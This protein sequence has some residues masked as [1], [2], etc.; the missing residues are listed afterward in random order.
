MK[1]S[2]HIWKV[3]YGLSTRVEKEEEPDEEK[4]GE[5]ED[6]ESEKEEVVEKEGEKDDKATTEEQQ[7]EQ[8]VQDTQFPP[9][10]PPHIPSPPHVITPPAESAKVK[11]V[12][13]TSGQSINPLTAE[14]LKKILHQTTLQSELC[15]NP[16]LVS[17]E[18][19]QKAM[20]EITKTKVNPQEPPSHV[21][22]STPDQPTEQA[23]KETPAKVDASATKDLQGPKDTSVSTAQGRGALPKITI[24]DQGR[25]E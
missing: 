12:P 22:T 5:E 21:S 13:D 9:P 24:I 20:E 2:T 6:I 7:Q 14:D 1:K 19:L 10:S 11:D 4:D 3:I 8:S 16:V 15:S 18:E 25:S 23:V 17:V